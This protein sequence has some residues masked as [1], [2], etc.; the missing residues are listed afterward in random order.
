MRILAVSAESDLWTTWING[1]DDILRLLEAGDPKGA[2]A[3]Y[4]QIYVEYRARVEVEL[5]IN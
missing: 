3:R 2:I 4:K 1:H 5:L